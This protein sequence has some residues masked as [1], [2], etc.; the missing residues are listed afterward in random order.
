M[1]T[2]ALWPLQG[3]AEAY[4]AVPDDEGTVSVAFGANVTVG[5]SRSVQGRWVKLLSDSDELRQKRTEQPRSSGTVIRVNED[6][7]SGEATPASKRTPSRVGEFVAGAY[8][9]E[10]VI[11]EGR[12]G[13]V[14]RATRVASDA[15]VAL[16]LLRP[17]ILH[18]NEDA[19]G[20]FVDDA[21]AVRK[22][23]HANIAKVL[24][25]SA[26]D[27]S[28]PFLAMEWLDG[29]DLDA[30]VQLQ[31]KVSPQI[32]ADFV[33]QACEGMAVAHAAGLLHRDLKLTNLFLAKDKGGKARIKILDFGLARVKPLPIDGQVQGDE[34][35]GSPA[36]LSPE[37]ITGEVLDER[38]DVWSLGAVLYELVTGRSAFRA[39][40][41]AQTLVNITIHQPPPMS[42]FAED[43]PLG[44]QEIVDRCLSK[45][46]ADRYESVTELA[47]ELAKFC[48]DDVNA[49]PLLPDRP[50][51]IMPP[52]P[53]SISGPIKIEGTLRINADLESSQF[54]ISL[55]PPSGGKSKRTVI[56][57]I[58]VGALIGGVL[59]AIFASR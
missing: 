29:V 15:R 56:I 45:D 3:R 17:E 49:A 5:C 22:L 27:S 37:Q 6:Q 51:S 19:F 4:A 26:K 28:E 33:R 24:A 32:A 10:K 41:A 50:V 34:G 55:P 59:A 16:K 44:L 8:K 20:R 21:E 42:T 13:V 25:V 36:F 2:R 31:E 54:R 9:I 53:A 58:A 43:V 57:M 40:N 14:A 35:G 52:P 39:E 12:L 46:R 23:D 30:L 11:A 38:T 18:A 48:E 1:E 7:G 47:E